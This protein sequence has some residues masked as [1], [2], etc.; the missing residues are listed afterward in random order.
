MQC[1]GGYVVKDDGELTLLNTFGITNLKVSEETVLCVSITPKHDVST[2][3]VYNSPWLMKGDLMESMQCCQLLLLFKSC[4]WLSSRKG[5]RLGFIHY[6]ILPHFF[7]ICMHWS[8]LEEDLLPLV[9]VLTCLR[10]L[11]LIACAGSDFCLKRGFA[12][13][14]QLQLSGAKSSVPML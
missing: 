14:Q 9:E 11:N 7:S 8:I 13:L 4:I 3:L 2:H 10:R 5:Y 12:M 6:T 1:L